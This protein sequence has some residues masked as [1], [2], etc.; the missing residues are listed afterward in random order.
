MY[1]IKQDQGNICVLVAFFENVF[2][3]EGLRKYLPKM[4]QI[5][6]CLDSIDYTVI[7]PTCIFEFDA[8][9]TLDALKHVPDL[10]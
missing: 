6:K 8:K 1:Q 7:L 4:I 9:N 10:C 3:P 5:L 2:P